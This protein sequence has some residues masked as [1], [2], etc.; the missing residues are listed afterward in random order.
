MSLWHIFQDFL[1]NY[2]KMMIAVENK[3]FISFEMLLVLF[4]VKSIFKLASNRCHQSYPRQLKFWDLCN[5]TQG[6][7]AKSYSSNEIVRFWN[8]RLFKV[9]WPLIIINHSS[10]NNK[11]HKKVQRPWNR[12]E[13]VMRIQIN[14][15]WWNLCVHFRF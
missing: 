15:Y 8:E 2:P 6:I 10:L 11:G 14:T 4:Q 9:N 13:P 7:F 12:V 1:V 5:L 3:I